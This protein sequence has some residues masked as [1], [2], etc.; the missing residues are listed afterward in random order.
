MTTYDS[1]QGP[2]G[3]T[4]HRVGVVIEVEPGKF[5][6]AVLGAHEVQVDIETETHDYLDDDYML[7]V[8]PGSRTMRL[9]IEGTLINEYEQTERPEWATEPAGAIEPAIRAIGADHG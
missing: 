3:P 8:F 1:R 2:K 5:M 7:R 9:E 6:K 4:Y